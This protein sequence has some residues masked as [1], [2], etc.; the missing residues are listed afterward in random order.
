MSFNYNS[1]DSQ[2][3]GF[4]IPESSIVFITKVVI[5]SYSVIRGFAQAFFETLES[6]YNLYPPYRG[7]FCG[8]VQ[9]LL[10]EMAYAHCNEDKRKEANEGSSHPLKEPSAHEKSCMKYSR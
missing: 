6:F 3:G 9:D 4:N 5:H 1:E 8:L 7:K 10:L 2:I